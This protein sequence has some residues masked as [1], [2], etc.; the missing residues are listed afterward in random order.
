VALPRTYVR[1]ADD[2]PAGFD[3]GT[4]LAAVRAGRSFGTTGPLLEVDLAG[5]GPGERF[6]G[7]AGELRL[8]ARAAPW[9]PVCGPSCS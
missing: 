3:E 9:V 5:A 2:R 6:T 8:L 4:F 7:A 1:L